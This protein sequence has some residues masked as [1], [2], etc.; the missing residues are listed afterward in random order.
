MRLAD[1]TWFIGKGD[2]G[3]FLNELRGL[4]RV[5]VPAE[6]GDYLDYEPLPDEFSIS[7]MPIAVIR[8]TSS[9]KPFVLPVRMPVARYGLPSGTRELEDAGGVDV[10]VVGPKACDCRALDLM[11]RV[12]L[13]G[14]VTDPFYKARRDKLTVISTDCT[15]PYD[16]CFCTLVG[17]NPYPDSGFDINLS[18][19]RDGFIAESGSAKGAELV[20]RFRV[21]FLEADK[22]QLEQR[23]KNR[24]ETRRKLLD[25]NREFKLDRSR[26]ELVTS[27]YHSEAWEY[28]VRN[29]VE[30]GACN[31]VC[32]TCHCFFLSD[33]RARAGF[34]RLRQWDGCMLAGYSRMAGGLTPRLRLVDRFRNRYVCK[35]EF[36]KSRYGEE[37]CVG[38][39]RCIVA[40]MGK[41]D[42]RAVL[43]DV[44]MH[45]VIARET[46]ELR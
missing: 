6:M 44:E 37:Y 12:F 9:L 39:G 29:C 5:Y 46:G 25:I 40:C 1:K 8:T 30:C 11:D 21:F 14:E 19:V 7:S 18:P 31:F 17:L 38:C 10:F 2:L 34:E 32:P 26:D 43:R 41:I 15:E 23:R 28:H 20:K 35:F 36:E 3:R 42:M 33:H 16:T 22:E 13:E 4:G 45:P 24:Q 27:N